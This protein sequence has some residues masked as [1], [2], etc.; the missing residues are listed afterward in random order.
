MNPFALNSRQQIYDH[1]H[2]NVSNITGL[3]YPNIPRLKGN[4]ILGRLLYL[5]SD[6]GILQN[7]IASGQLASNHPSGLCYYWLANKLVLLVTH[8]NHIKEA[9][10]DHDADISRRTATRFIERF[11]GPNIA[12]DQNDLWKKKRTI[13]LKYLAEREAL[14]KQES[15][16][17]AV[18]HK[19]IE[20]I[21]IQQEKE[22]NLETILK[23]FTLDNILNVMIPYEPQ[24]NTQEFANYTHFVGNHVANIRN[25]FKWS[26]PGFLRKLIYWNEKDTPQKIKSH[27]QSSLNKML[28]CP[29]RSSI[30]NNDNFIRA[31]W[32]INKN[33][34]GQADLLENADVFGD[35]NALFFTAQDTVTFSL[36]FAIKLLCAHPEVKAQL[37]LELEQHRV[38]PEHLNAEEIHKLDYLDCVVKEILRLYPAS[39]TLPPRGVD[40]PFKMAGLSLGKGD[41]ILVSPYLTH[42]ISSIWKNPEQFDPTRFSRENSSAIPTHAYLPFGDGRHTCPGWKFAYLQIKFFL[43]AVF[44]T[45]EVKMI[46]NDFELCFEQTTL[47]PRHPSYAIFSRRDSSF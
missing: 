40:R 12:I 8:P 44:S 10:I 9:L 15:P 38:H 19:Y 20:Q 21:K 34:T 45:F 33:K 5:L 31:I 25:I 35:T 1:F 39:P 23:G 28:F 7:L 42:R 37:C 29:Y 16:M 27:M 43:A 41:L 2:R 18:I 32:N 4:F 30:E 13:Y 11:W 26:L 3:R 22:V 17:K 47:R 46:H 14:F 36:I 6:Q 24:R